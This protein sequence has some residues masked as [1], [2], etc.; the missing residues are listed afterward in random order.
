VWS[1][2]PQRD[3]L[4]ALVTRIR[5]FAADLF[6]GCGIEWTVG[7]SG[8]LEGAALSPELRWN[9]LM[10]MKEAIHNIARHADARR[11]A[12][13]VDHSS[14][15]TLTIQLHDDG[16]GFSPASGT[17]GETAGQGLRGMALRA[18]EIGGELTIDTEVGVGTSITLRL[19]RHTLRRGLGSSAKG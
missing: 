6:E 15:G 4:Q 14:S 11:V 12:L 18:N 1:I 3:D 9:L 10:I 7:A 8:R 16:R 5:T 2:H 13:T 19:P 17:T